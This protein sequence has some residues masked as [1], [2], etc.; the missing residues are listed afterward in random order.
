[1]SVVCSVVVPTR[2]SAAGVCG[3]R[4]AA[5]SALAMSPA[6]LTPESTTQRAVVAYWLQSTLSWAV[7]TVSSRWSL[8]VSGM[9][10]YAGDR[11]DRGHAR[12]DLEADLGLGARE[13]L[14]GAGG[15]EE[16]VADHEAD[17]AGLLAVLDDDLGRAAWVSG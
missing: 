9:P 5:I 2:V 17:D 4:P 12:H 10:A 7:T 14:L 13:R 1:M 3:E 6:M 16:R 11:G 8:V 15:V